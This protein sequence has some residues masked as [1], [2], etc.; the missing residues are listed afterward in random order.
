MILTKHTIMSHYQKGNRFWF[1]FLMSVGCFPINYVCHKR[2]QKTNG[3]STFIKWGVRDLRN[4]KDR[5]DI[6]KNYR[7]LPFCL[8]PRDPV[9]PKCTR[10]SHPISLLTLPFG[11]RLNDRRKAPQQDPSRTNAP[12]HRHLIICQLA[13]D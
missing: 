4:K 2:N 3:S 10:L 11:R 12:S 5:Q 8:L 13:R 9:P 7:C 6:L 1:V